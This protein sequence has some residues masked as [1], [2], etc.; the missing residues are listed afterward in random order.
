MQTKWRALAESKL[1]SEQKS[2]INLELKLYKENVEGSKYSEVR[3]IL[4]GEKFGK[5]KFDYLSKI[6]MEAVWMWLPQR[7]CKK[8]EF[9]SNNAF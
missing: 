5:K 1:N 4:P 2:N 7:Y 9:I 3:V 6:Q 8:L